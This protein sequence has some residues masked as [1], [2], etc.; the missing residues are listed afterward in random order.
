MLGSIW[1]ITK[2]EKINKIIK[3]LGEKYNTP[4]FLPHI[5][6][7]NGFESIENNLINLGKEIK[8]LFKDKIILKVK[9]I[10]YSPLFTKTL[11]LT[12]FENRQLQDL[13]EKTESFLASKNISFNRE[14]SPH[15]SLIYKKMEEKEKKKIIEEISHSLPN[16]ITMDDLILIL[17]E[18]PI[19]KPEDVKRW[20]YID[21]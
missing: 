15:L 8:K 2:D 6:L 10:E 12:F 5:T 9:N 14:F 1:L 21:L 18:K 13:R 16:E 20:K 19:E 4:Y 7:V 3:E 17:E 11:Y